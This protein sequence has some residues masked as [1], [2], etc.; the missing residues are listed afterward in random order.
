[1]K[2]VL[3]AGNWKMNKGI[4]ESAEFSKQLKEV[5]VPEGICAALLVPFIDL[6]VVKEALS[7]TEILVGAQNCHFESKGAF[8]GEISVPM[9]SET[10]TDLCI[11]GHSER[12][13]YFAESNDI[14]NKKLN[15]LL[16]ADIRPILC[17]GENISVRDEGKEY[18][19]VGS[20]LECCLAEINKHKIPEIII[21]YEPIWAIG[22]GKTATPEQAQN[23]CLFIRRKLKKLTSGMD[24]ERIMILYGGSVNPDNADEILKQDDIDGAL[25]GGAS[26]SVQSFVE[27]LNSACRICK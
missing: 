6:P 10:G 12:R 22:T 15:A 18:E 24:E 21:A 20:Q 26:L 7:G 13:Q 9:L 25:V 19:F 3:I 27:I 17:V 4:S 14:C 23:M 11:V 2:K 5:G 16:D 8:T 1:M